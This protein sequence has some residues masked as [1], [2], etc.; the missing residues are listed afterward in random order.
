MER[1]YSR[2]DIRAVALLKD[3]EVAAVTAALFDL[4]LDIR[5]ARAWK[6]EDVEKVLSMYRDGASVSS[7]ASIVGRT[8]AAIGHLVSRH[9]VRRRWGQQAP[10]QP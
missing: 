2:G 5:P 4:G 7:I 8:S 6:P 10:S 9:H 3:V 1:T